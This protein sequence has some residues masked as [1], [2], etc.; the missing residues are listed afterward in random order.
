MKIAYFDCFSGAAGDMIVGAFLDAGASADHLREE[1]A[2]LNL[3]EVD[4]RIEKVNKAGFSATSFHPVISHLNHTTHR[5]LPDILKII[6]QAALSSS[7]QEKASRIFTRLAEAEARVHDCA[8]EKI[9][10]HEVGAADAIMDIVGAA[11]ALESLGIEKVFCSNLTV[12]GGTVQCEHGIMPVPAPATAELIK[13][14]EITPTDIQLELLTPTGAAILTELSESFG[15][16]PPMQIDATGFGAGQRDL[17]NQPNVLRLLIGQSAQPDQTSTL[18]D[19]VVVLEANIDDATPELIGHVTDQLTQAGALDVYC[20]SIAMKKNRPATSISIIS[21]PQDTTKLEGILFTECTTLGIRRHTC[22][23]S[24][25]ERQTKTV[26]TPY[27]QIRIKI[28]YYNGNPVTQAA[29]FEDCQ[30]A[31]RQHN[32]PLKTIMTEAILAYQNS[33]HNKQ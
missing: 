10:F 20:T 28:G 24:L 27:G 23:R 9:H 16:I 15:P 29:E 13:G 12:G 22:Q 32:V 3:T 17:P 1:L 8:V 6:A 7:V 33:K 26:Q 14:I 5:H 18:Q 4:L 25:L 30:K 11:A 2:K 31:A 19:V 21:R